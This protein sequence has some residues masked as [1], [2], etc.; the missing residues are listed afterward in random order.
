MSIGFGLGRADRDHLALLQHAQ[1][2]HLRRR[3]RLAD[4]VEEERAVAGRG[5][6]TALILHA[7]VNDPFT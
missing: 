6:E 2:L 1:Q 5:E 4:L 7:P 3:R